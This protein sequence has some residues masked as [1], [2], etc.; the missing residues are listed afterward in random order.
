M[1]FHFSLDLFIIVSRHFLGKLTLQISL[2]PTEYFLFKKD[3]KLI[4]IRNT[5]NMWS[6]S[7]YLGVG[8]RGRRSWIK[9]IENEH[10]SALDFIAYSPH[11]LRIPFLR[12]MNVFRVDLYGTIAEE[13]SRRRE[14]IKSVRVIANFTPP[15]RFNPRTFPWYCKLV[16]RQTRRLTGRF[17]T[18]FPRCAA[19]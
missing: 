15:I 8:K 19:A 3:I 9:Y 13:V 2:F 11:M 12:S 5:W 17:F 10:R 18:S 1:S 4:H 6:M 14:P 16:D 7:G